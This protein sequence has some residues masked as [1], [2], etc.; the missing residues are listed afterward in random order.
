VL[1]DVVGFALLVPP[2]RRY[3]RRRLANWIRARF[4]V[5][6]PGASWNASRDEIIDVR[7]LDDKRNQSD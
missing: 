2:S 1:T 6:R 5:G 7:V 3:A 4:M